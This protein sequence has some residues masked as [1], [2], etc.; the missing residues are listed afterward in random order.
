M[1]NLFKSKYLLI[2]FILIIVG[3][4]IYLLSGKNK[5]KQQSEKTKAVV[6][7]SPTCSCCM[8][9]SNYL[10]KNGFEVEIEKID[11]MRSIKEE[12]TIPY[13]MQSCHTTIIGDYF[14]E[15][16]VPIEA[17]NKL[18]E[19]KPDI[20]GI[21]LPGMPAGSPGMSGIKREEFIIYSL[22]NGDGSEFVRI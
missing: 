4:P 13:D 2:I 21:S 1:S 19:E 20:N 16:H 12:Y 11:D 22:I 3:L 14:I 5:P 15:G 17:I 10:R 9:H 7:K 18:L 8:S 6:Y